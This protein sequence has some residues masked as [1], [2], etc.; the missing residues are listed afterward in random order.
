VIAFLVIIAVAG[1]LAVAAPGDD[2]T[3]APASPKIEARTSR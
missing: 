2:G 3:G 1:I